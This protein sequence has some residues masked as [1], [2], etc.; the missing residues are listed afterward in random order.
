[1]YSMT[2]VNVFTRIVRYSNALVQSA[3]TCESIVPPAIIQ[4]VHIQRE[5]QE[6]TK[7]TASRIPRCPILCHG[8]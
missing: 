1:M 7:S 8:D 4:T 2:R 6:E 3:V 5:N